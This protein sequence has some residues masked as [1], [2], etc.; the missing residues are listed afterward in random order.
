VLAL[1]HR[2]D[3]PK[4]CGGCVA[5][6]WRPLLERLGAPEWLWSWPVRGLRLAAP[7][8][9]EAVR[10]VRAPAAWLLDRSRL[11]AW[12]ARRAGECGAEVL[13]AR[14]EEV[15][16]EP[17][18]ARVRAG[19]RLLRAD[20]LVGTDGALGVT[21]RS[22]GLG[23]PAWECRAAVEERA[24]PA[25]WAA[26]AEEVVIE[27][28]GVAGGYAWAFPRPGV[29]NLGVGF[30]RAAGAGGGG[31]ELERRLAGFLARQGLGRPKAWRG[32]VIPCAAGR[33]RPVARGRACVAGDAAGAADPFLGEGIGQ[34]LYTGRLAARAV[35][36]GDL[37]LYPRWLESLWREHR[38]A[39]LVAR[40]IY[41][42]P[43]FIH[44]VARRRPGALDYGFHLLT[45]R[46]G[47]PRLWAAALG[48]LTGLKPGLDH[49]DRA[50]YSKHLS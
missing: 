31:R 8:A 1:D 43:G 18:G 39:R 37:S 42:A 4:P 45:G 13:R 10:R 30:W 33:S 12:L 7:G 27:L 3:R 5:A 32:W 40:L 14:A 29:L 15:R 22:L 50:L 47:F 44:A 46:L 38:H 16:L 35:M 36:A 28:G 2:P 9:A 48:R 11:D 49:A 6:R 25:A 21:G 23:R 17:G 19:G 41:G 20:W 26:E 24:L 34:A